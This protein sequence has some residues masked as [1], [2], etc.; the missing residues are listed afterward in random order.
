MKDEPTY[1]K[2]TDGNGQTKNG[3]QW[4]PGVT[5]VASGALG[6]PLCSDGWLHFYR[7]PLLAALFCEAHVNFTEHQL[8]ECYVGLPVLHQA[9]KSGARSLTTI[10]KIRLPSI[11]VT[12]RVAFAILCAQAVLPAVADRWHDWARDWLS[13]RGRHSAAARVAAGAAADN[14]GACAA[15]AAAYAAYADADNAG[16]RAACAAAY[17]ADADA[18]TYEK[19]VEFAEQVLAEF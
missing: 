14:A 13:G 17:A 19:L 11:T 7:H 5:H 6:Q 16:A 8:W 2:L 12:Q 9:A 15:D 3:T 10:R 4:G 18:L 1:Y